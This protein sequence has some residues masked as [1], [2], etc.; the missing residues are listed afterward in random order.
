MESLVCSFCGKRYSVKDPVW[1]CECGHPLDLE[2]EAS[3]NPQGTP[4]Q[5]HGIWRYREALPLKNSGNIVSLGEG[6]TPILEVTVSGR[7]VLLK[8]EFLSP[9]GSFKDR[10]A[11]VLISKAQELGVKKVVEDSS[12]NAG[13]AIAAYSARAGIECHI[14]IPESTSP[15]KVLQIKAYGAEVFRVPGN[16]TEVARAAWEAS[17][18]AYYASHIWNPF[19]LQG[20]KTLAYEIFEQLNFQIPDTIIFPVGNGTLLIGA[21]LGFSELLNQ[22]LI[23]RLP[24]LVAAQAEACAP[25]YL[26]YSRKG[27]EI[28]EVIPQS[29]IAEGIVIPQPPRGKQVLEILRKTGGM[30]LQVKEREILEAMRILSSRGILAEP[31]SA[32]ALAAFLK[33]PEEWGEK[34]L[35]P[36]TGNGLKTI[37]QYQK[38]IF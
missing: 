16:R 15:G 14:Y 17:K 30:V 11:S 3:W 18:K 33:K 24:R 2:F 5:A 35:I 8:L 10:G 36:L 12:G 22:H 26:A 6:F 25:L 34:V 32:V 29:T 37:E 9:T 28:P 7:P 13:C 20:T 19:F 1:R 31:T 23:E 38:I 21:Y 27:G 4:D